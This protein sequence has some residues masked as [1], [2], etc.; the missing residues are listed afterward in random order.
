MQI[1]LSARAFERLLFEWAGLGGQTGQF[2]VGSANLSE[3]GLAEE[4]DEAM[5]QAGIGREQIA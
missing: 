4:L 1:E 2:S 3:G 5:R